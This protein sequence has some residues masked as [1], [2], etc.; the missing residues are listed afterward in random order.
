MLA[1]GQEFAGFAITRRLAAGGMTYLYVAVDSQQNRVVIRRLKPD[2]LRDKRIRNSF[3]H[4][5]EILGHLHHPNVIRLIKA[6]IYQDEPFMALEYIESRNLRDLILRKDPLIYQNT[7]TILRQMASAIAYVHLSGFLH[8]DIKPE[9]FIVRNDALVVLIDF[10]LATERKPK[11]VKISPL[12]GTFAYL[13]PETLLKNLVDEQTDIY[14]FGVTAYEMFT[15]HKPFEGVTL[16]DAKKNQLDPNGKPT[17]F[18]FHNVNLPAPMENLIYKCLA[19]RQSDRYPSM[20]LV[21]RD[22]ET[23]V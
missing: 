21:L 19:Y 23:M 17:R 3:L 5:A 15:G 9:N 18:R 12:P 10:D 22:L 11:P 6:G 20:S 8:L 7:L 1:V 16:E 4:G 2:Y 13:P 14:A